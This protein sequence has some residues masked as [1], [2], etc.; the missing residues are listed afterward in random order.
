MSLLTSHSLKNKHTKVGLSVRYRDEVVDGGRLYTRYATKAYSYVGMTY[1]A[2][3]A[4]AAE[5]YKQYRRIH[6][7]QEIEARTTTSTVTGDDGNTSTVASTYHAVNDK[8]VIDCLCT[9]SVTHGA[10]DSW[11]VEISVNETDTRASL[12]A[13]SDLDAL[14]ATENAWEYDET[15][16]GLEEA[17]SLKSISAVAGSGTISVTFTLVNYDGLKQAPQLIV[18]SVGVASRSYWTCEDCQPSAESEYRGTFT[19]GTVPNTACTAV[20]VYGTK[21]SKT[22]TFTPS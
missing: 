3:K 1:A 2:A 6:R 22:V 10:G 13:V 8:F 21:V 17:L 15:V 16:D 7:K 9:I 4:C 19:G 18:A 14:F 20:L 5:K 12:E 11:D